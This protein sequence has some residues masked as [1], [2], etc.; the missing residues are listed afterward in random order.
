MGV[1][2][3]RLPMLFVSPVT[4]VWAVLGDDV[5]YVCCMVLCVSRSSLCVVLVSSS[6][7]GAFV[8]WSELVGV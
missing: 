6:D 1:G 7:V 2:C 4:A 3:C 8:W 5:V